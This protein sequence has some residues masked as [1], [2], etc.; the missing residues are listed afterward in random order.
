VEQ[1]PTIPQTI[2]TPNAICVAIEGLCEKTTIGLDPGLDRD[3]WGRIMV[4][5]AKKR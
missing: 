4:Y 1:P 2:V 3:A 5:L